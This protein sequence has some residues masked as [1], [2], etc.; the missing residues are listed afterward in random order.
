MQNVKTSLYR[1]L[2]FQSNLVALRLKQKLGVKEM[3]YNFFYTKNI[4]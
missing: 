4:P 1:K 3:F 2:N